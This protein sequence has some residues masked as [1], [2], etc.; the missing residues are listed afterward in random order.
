MP[1]LE[2]RFLGRTGLKVSVISLGSWVTYGGHVTDEESFASLKVAYDAGVNFFDTAENYSA[3]AAE[4]V[5]G[6]AIKHFGWKQNDLVISTKVY[7]GQANSAHPERPLNNKG[8]SRKHIVEGV[9]ASL[10]RLQLPYVDVVFAHRPDRDT[11]I[12]ETVRAINHVIDSGKAFYWGTS[13]WSASEIADAWR[14]ADKL[15]LIGPVVEQPQYNLLVRSR[16]ESEYR[17]LYEKYGL[18]LTIWSPLKQG[19]LTGKYNGHSSPP[20]GSRLAE[21]KDPF[22]IAQS[23]GFGDEKWKQE[24]DLVEKLK[25]IAEELGTTLGGLA[26]AWAVKN[27][28]VSSVIIGASRPEQVTENLKALD[29]VGKLTDEILAKIDGALENKPEV[30]RRFG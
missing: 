12:E 20:P 19:I 21:A 8:L 11:P 13:E 10:E 26:I 3:G 16:V 1:Q 29:V 5:L 22:T 6:K 25:P 2:Y 30:P 23:K 9:N 28:N 27:K 17:W 4:V 18:G 15:G 7:H 14:A 24:L